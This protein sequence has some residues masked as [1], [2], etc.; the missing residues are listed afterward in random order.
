MSTPYTGSETLYLLCLK[1][2]SNNRITINENMMSVYLN[3]YIITMLGERD[4][5]QR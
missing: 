1:N 3:R 2:I 4:V 5:A